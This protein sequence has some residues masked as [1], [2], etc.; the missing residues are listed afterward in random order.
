[1][2]RIRRI[3]NAAGSVRQSW[4]VSTQGLKPIREPSFI[5]R[6]TNPPKD[7]ILSFVKRISFGNKS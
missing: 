1:M 6:E 7:R 5:T 2:R 4:L 3:V